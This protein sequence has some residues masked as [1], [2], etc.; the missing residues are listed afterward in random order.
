MTDA[1]LTDRARA[2]A[3]SRHVDQVDK[4][5]V[6]IAAHLEDVA[7]RVQRRGEAIEAIAWV[8][9]V[10][11]DHLARLDEVEALLGATIAQ[12]VQALARQPG[13]VYFADYIPRVL[14]QPDARI[15]K[16][17]D[18]CHNRGKAHLIQDQKARKSLAKRYDRVLRLI[19]EADPDLRADA[20][21]DL[22]YQDGSWR[23]A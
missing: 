5:G 15:I 3:L 4:L 7:R 21:Y 8:H 11:E 12:A 1:P 17:A 19:A 20:W 14:A 23:R 9:D 13:E 16:H 22:V 2:F 18:A 10:V 6:P